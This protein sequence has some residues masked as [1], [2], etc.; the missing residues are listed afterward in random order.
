MFYKLYIV[1]YKK[2]MFCIHLNESKKKIPLLNRSHL[3]LYY[4]FNDTNFRLKTIKNI[5]GSSFNIELNI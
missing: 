3:R 1:S 5:T 2:I 4:L